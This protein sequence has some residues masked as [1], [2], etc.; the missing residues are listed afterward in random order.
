M[1]TEAKI[2]PF[3]ERLPNDGMRFNFHEGHTKAWDS[4]ARLVGVFAGTKSGKTVFIPH[5][6]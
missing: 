6:I 1:V 3:K 4:T 2:P 5:W